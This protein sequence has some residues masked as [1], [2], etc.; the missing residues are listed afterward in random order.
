MPF[1]SG[2]TYRNI[3]RCIVSGEIIAGPDL[4]ELKRQLV[5]YFGVPD[6]VLCGSGSLALELALRVCGLRA[7]DEVIIPSFCCS[8]VVAPILA[9]GA[10]PVLADVGSELNLT[11]ETVDA[12]RTTRTRA[13]IVPHLFGNPADIGAIAELGNANNIV[14]IDDAAQA[15]GATIDDRPAGSCGDMGVVSFGAEKVCFGLGGGALVAHSAGVLDAA[16]QIALGYPSVGS[17]LAQI[18]F[19]RGSTPLARLDLAFA[20][21]AFA[22]S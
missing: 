11:V 16:R 10:T 2:D 19:D 14:V 6:I 13:I 18:S 21:P 8:T 17:T 7:G 1:W 15:L 12:A 20:T 9:V 4:V 22:W 3:R 5:E